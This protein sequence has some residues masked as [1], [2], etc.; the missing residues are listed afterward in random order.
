MFGEKGFGCTPY[1]K[2]PQ[3]E[4]SR[5]FGAGKSLTCL[6]CLC[7]PGAVG[8]FELQHCDAPNGLEDYLLLL[9]LAQE[10]F[11]HGCFK[12]YLL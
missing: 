8:W 3:N 4:E 1:P 2:P 9:W 5:I 7:G 10:L 6:D 12:D 11:P